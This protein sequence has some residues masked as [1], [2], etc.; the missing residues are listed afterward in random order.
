MYSIGVLTLN[1]E[2]MNL[3]YKQY[4]WGLQQFYGH[5]LTAKLYYH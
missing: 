3:V 4:Y 5:S 2:Q 1:P